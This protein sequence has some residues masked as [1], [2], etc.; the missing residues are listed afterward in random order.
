MGK[1]LIICFR[2]RYVR[3]IDSWIRWDAR[4]LLKCIIGKQGDL[5][6]CNEPHYG[7]YPNLAQRA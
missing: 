3:L 4:L 7:L 6:V 2:H 1:I 5:R